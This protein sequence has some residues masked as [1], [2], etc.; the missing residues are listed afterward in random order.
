MSVASVASR[1]AKS[2]LELAVEQNSLDAVV[3]DMKSFS[4]ALKSKDLK[5]FLKSPIIKSGK[6]I[7]VYDAVFGGKFNPL[8]DS[9]ARLIIK[10]GREQFMP[11]IASAFI[12]Q[13]NAYKGVSLI[14]LTSATEIGSEMAEAIKSKLK[15]SSE[16]MENVDLA[17]DVD[18]N[19]I[20]G[21]KIEI[22]D[23]LYDASVA[24]KLELLR[25]EFSN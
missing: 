10:K 25:K 6:K 15:N 1:Y 5:Q 18:E 13:Y 3:D 7:A 11:E 9:F 2:L 23:K 8:F 14:K 19:L 24:H 21:F 20:G 12:D 4:V 17:F 22:G 16:T